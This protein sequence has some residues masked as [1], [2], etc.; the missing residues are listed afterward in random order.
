MGRD[1]QPKHRQARRLDRKLN[2]RAS[3]DRILIV[4]EGSK[5]EPHYFDEIRNEFKLHTAN[6]QVQPSAWGTDPKNVVDY[7]NHLFIDGD[8]QKNIRPRSFEKVYVVFDRDDHT[9][10]FEAL[11]IAKKLNGTLLND[12]RQRLEFHAMPSIPCF[13]LWLLLHFEDIHHMLHRNEVYQRLRTHIPSYSKG[14]DNCFEVTK[15][16]FSIACDRANR[17]SENSDPH[18]DT[19][20]YTDIHKLVELLINLRD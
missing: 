14:M 17:L 6:V 19:T 11:A 4:S 8:A 1:N 5:T 16:F 9:N 13:E 18:I 3:Y 7:A 15:E 20:P 2:N 10:Y 12:V